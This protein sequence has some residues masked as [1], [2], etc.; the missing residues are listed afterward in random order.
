MSLSRTVRAREAAE[1]ATLSASTCSPDTETEDDGVIGD[2]VADGDVE[3]ELTSHDHDT[4]KN[5]PPR[6][7]THPHACRTVGIVADSPLPAT[8]AAVGVGVA[9]ASDALD[10][11]VDAHI[12]INTTV[13]DDGVAEGIV[14]LGQN[15]SD[16]LT[17]GAPPG[18]LGA[19][20]ATPRM[21]TNNFTL[22]TSDI[23][24]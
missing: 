4:D 9:G 23:N 22:N 5:M 19:I 13:G 18:T 21:R 11:D 15:V 10:V 3:I 14:A 24:L 20:D 8:T 16:D 7:P 12:I 6:P 1:S 17:M 2:P